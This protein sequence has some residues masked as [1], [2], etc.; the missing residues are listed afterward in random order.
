MDEKV[1]NIIPTLMEEMAS[2]GENESRILLRYYMRCNRQEKAVVKYIYVSL[3]LDF[4]NDTEEVRDQVD[5]SGNPIIKN[6][7]SLEPKP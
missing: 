6:T 3:R 5:E 4:S 1:D 7:V 2:D